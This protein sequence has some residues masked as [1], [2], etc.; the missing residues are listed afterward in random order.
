MPSGSSDN[1]QF[2]LSWKVWAEHE[3]IFPLLNFTLHG[4]CS[5]FSASSGT[6]PREI[7]DKSIGAWTSLN[8]R[9]RNMFLIFHFL[10][11][12][13]ISLGYNGLQEQPLHYNVSGTKFIGVLQ[14]ACRIK[15]PKP[16]RGHALFLNR[17]YSLF[18]YRVF[19][20]N[21]MRSMCVATNATHPTHKWSVRHG[22]N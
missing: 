3:L 9:Y 2:P 1:I 20:G 10:I 13:A 22:S 21:T 12:K 17:M 15:T 5:G 6:A 14:E 11:T 8:K 16:C 18:P 4:A 19:V 7:L